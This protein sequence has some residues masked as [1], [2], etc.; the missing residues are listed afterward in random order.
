M[1]PGIQTPKVPVEIVDKA[2]FMVW[3]MVWKSKPFT[4]WASFIN[5]CA[6]CSLGFRI[7]RQLVPY[8]P[9]ISCS[10]TLNVATVTP[11]PYQVCKVV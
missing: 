10:P 8:A 7:G 3:W 11:Y 5:L 6:S 9:I 4:V 1:A 2:L